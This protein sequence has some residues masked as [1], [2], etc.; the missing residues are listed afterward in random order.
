MIMHWK[1]IIKKM[2]DI[3][4]ILAGYLME[5]LIFNYVKINYGMPAFLHSR[6]HTPYLNLSV[7]TFPL[8][9]K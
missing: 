4:R 3:V 8:M 7:H 9:I 5:Y 6:G 1:S 2:Y